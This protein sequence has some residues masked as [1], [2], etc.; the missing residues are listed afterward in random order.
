MLN[1]SVP[2]RSLKL[3]DVECSY[4]TW[5]GD[6]LEHNVS[7]EFIYFFVS[8]MTLLRYISYNYL[9]TIINK[10]HVI[11]SQKDV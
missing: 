10:C 6:H 4:S 11:L 1:K 8:Y 3:N 2:V 9:Y 7:L 5:M